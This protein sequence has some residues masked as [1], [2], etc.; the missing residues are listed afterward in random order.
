MFWIKYKLPFFLK[1]QNLPIIFTSVVRIHLDRDFSDIETC[2]FSGII[3]AIKPGEA[4]YH[5]A[6]AEYH[7]VAIS[8][9][10]R[11]MKGSTNSNPFEFLTYVFEPLQIL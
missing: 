6:L 5:S 10:V 1:S 11:R 4:Q 7:C 9:A 2:G 8:L 3:F